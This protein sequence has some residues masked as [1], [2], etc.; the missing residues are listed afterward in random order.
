MLS[1]VIHDK[2]NELYI[3]YEIGMYTL[4]KKHQYFTQVQLEMLVIETNVCN[5]VV[6]TPHETLILKIKKKNLK[7][8]RIN[9]VPI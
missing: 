5:F 8:P 3:T 6:S 2:E 4:N 1:Q 7:S 9:Y